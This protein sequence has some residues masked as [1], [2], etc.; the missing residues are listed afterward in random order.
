MSES[1]YDFAIWDGSD[2]Q[3][4]KKFAILDK[5]QM[6]KSVLQTRKVKILRKLSNVF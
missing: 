3:V 4:L 5:S 2:S 6:A 1:F